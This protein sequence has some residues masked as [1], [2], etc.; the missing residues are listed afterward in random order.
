MNTP[1][2]SRVARV[3]WVRRDSA[4]RAAAALAGAFAV[5]VLASCASSQGKVGST[6]V[7]PTNKGSVVEVILK[8]YEIVMPESMPAGE[9]T[10]NITNPEV[11]TTIWK[12]T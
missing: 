8:D 7:T 2:L 1:F 12:S 10:C 9:A 4:S 11:T 6:Q 5:I 3:R